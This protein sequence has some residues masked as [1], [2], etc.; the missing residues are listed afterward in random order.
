MTSEH[1]YFTVFIDEEFHNRIHQVR[2]HDMVET[3]WDFDKL[4]SFPETTL[5]YNWG[6]TE[7][8]GVWEDDDLTPI[9]LF[10]YRIGAIQYLLKDMD[11]PVGRIRDLNWLL[12]NLGI[13]NSTHPNYNRLMAILTYYLPF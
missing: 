9:N 13:N 1:E 3:K 11:V 5:V 6:H 7:E 10:L 12:R 2:Q 8:D 4:L